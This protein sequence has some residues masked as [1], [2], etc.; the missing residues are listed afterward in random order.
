MPKA[1]Y[2]LST[3][4]DNNSLLNLK[5]DTFERMNKLEEDLNIPD[6]K[7]IPI[8]EYKPFIP[9]EIDSDSILKG[10]QKLPSLKEALNSDN[11]EIRKAAEKAME[12]QAVRNPVYHG[13][14]TTQKVPYTEGQEKFTDNSWLKGRRNT[15]Y[16]YN[17]YISM[18]ENEDFMN[19]HVWDSYTN[20]GKAW[21]GV[22]LFTGRT[23]S[24]AVTGLVGL[25]GDIGSIVWNGLQELGDTM[26]INDGTK[27]NFWYDVSNNWLSRKM[28]EADNHVKQQW[29]P[30]YKAMNYDNKGAWE[31]LMDPYTWTNSFADGAGF[32][33]QFAVPG[34]MLGKIGQA[35]RLASRIG[36]LEEALVTAQAANDAVKVAK[37]TK[38]IAQAK[39]V[40]AFT[41]AMGYDINNKFAAG[42]ARTFTG[43][44]NVGG[45]SAHVFNT[46]ME[47]VAETKEGFNS[48]VEELMRK[49]ISRDKAIEIAGENAPGQFWINTAILTA[50]NAFENKL[51]QK[52]V[53]NRRLT[54]IDEL[55]NGT[56]PKNL[57]SP[58][59]K[60]GKFFENN[61]WG[62]RIKFYGTNAAKSSFWEGF[63]EEN[64]QTAA[65][66]WAKG[67]Y[68]RQGDDGGATEEAGKLFVSQLW[69]QTKDAIKGNDRE[70]ADSIMA[71]AVIGILGNAVF[72]KLAS[73]RG[74]IYDTDGKTILKPKTFLPEGQR[75]AEIRQKAQKVAT[76]INTRDA[77]LSI[78]TFGGD[79]Y[80]KDGTVN[81][82]KADKKT[83]EI[84]EKLSK[85]NSV[86]GNSLKTED[87]LDDMSKNLL[88]SKVFT[89]YVKA[90]I[91]N[92][93]G[94]ALVGRLESWNTKT[95][96]ELSIY[97]VTEETKDDANKWSSKAKS[98]VEAYDKY[99]DIKYAAP[100]DTLL[101]EYQN[102]TSAIR[103]VL[104]DYTGYRDI[105]KEMSS[106][107]NVL[108]EQNNPFSDHP[109]LQDYN[110]NQVKLIKL[111]Q[112][113]ENEELDIVQKQAIEKQIEEIEKEQKAKKETFATQNETKESK[114][115]LVFPKDTDQK[116]EAERIAQYQD[117]FENL[118]NKVDS[119]IETEKFNQLIKEYSDPKTGYS[120]FVNG[121]EYFDNAYN[122]PADE[123]VAADTVEEIKK[124]TEEL[125]KEVEELKSNV[126]NATTK[127]E[128]DSLL[129]KIKEKEEEIAKQEEEILATD[130]T[131]VP[132]EITDIPELP[133]EKQYGTDDYIEQALAYVTPFKTVNKETIDFKDKEG[134]RLWWK[135]VALEHGY[136]HDLTVFAKFYQNEL[137]KFPDK[138]ELF[139][140]KDTVEL[141]KQRLSKTQMESFDEGNFKEGAVVVFR[142]KGKQE[143]LTFKSGK[144]VAFSYNQEAFNYNYDERVRINSE[145]TN[146]SASEVIEFFK[147]QQA[148]LEAVR[149]AVISQDVQIPINLFLGL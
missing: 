12:M 145:R 34:A 127:E 61:A 141:M 55:D 144:T 121:V 40:N 33:L 11:R 123:K 90:H 24:K 147:K 106:K 124:T 67:E 113:L 110:Q 117:F 4:F 62:N 38:T 28:E 82:E 53:N 41:K 139:V 21:R 13:V 79:I 69:K 142:E 85:I 56:L 134:N 133:T 131:V 122:K 111:R 70:A 66:R 112:K 143:W 115:G 89:E 45:I 118:G 130:T 65:A 126:E 14:G 102:I 5:I 72:S 54:L 136:D 74:E 101:S 100:S 47:S 23:L 43:S 20:F 17:P 98:L 3:G 132:E 18:D 6:Y 87:L 39:N 96:E 138:Y 59:T 32:L 94:D 104:L 88:E 42:F 73:T 75:K 29:L 95:P 68:N 125:K 9:K 76:F 31:K 86:F 148:I 35:G 77:W 26:N 49:G 60:V 52:A 92:E 91:L 71:G 84:R 78:N 2:D 114:E 1:L 137:V 99:K 10:D 109:E 107:Y 135:E 37:L 8:P 129:E 57:A 119:D 44:D 97:G 128:R 25:V 103:S 108:M 80:N 146:R 19:K 105:A 116:K 140:I 93:T 36:Q 51:L 64:A 27:N 15:M 120:K 149:E 46:M 7:S 30:T 58:T 16:G 63:W 22:G 81:Q 48:T 83:E 50:S